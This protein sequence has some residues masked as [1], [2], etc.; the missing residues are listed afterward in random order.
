MTIRT[1]FLAALAVAAVMAS[2]VFAQEQPPPPS[3]QPPGQTQAPGQAAG[4]RG[5]GGPGRAGRGAAPARGGGRSPDGFPQFIRPLASQDVL[6]RG[7]SLYQGNCESCHAA[8]LRG[9]LNK[10]PNLLRSAVAMDDEHGELIGPNVSK[11]NP[12]LNLVADD[13]VAISEYIHSI[14]ATMGAQGSPP[15]RNPVGLQLNVLVGDAQAG[16]A[17]F[18][19]HCASCHSATGDLKGIAAK[20]PDP[21]ALQNA[22]VA[23]AS[24]AG[25]FGGASET[26]RAVT[27]QMPNGQKIDGKLVREDDFDVVLTV[28]DGARRYIPI[29]KGVTV[30]VADPQAAHKKMVLELDD[31]ENKNMHDVT[32]YLATLK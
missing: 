24:G 22:W 17:Y 19:G 6:L 25:G 2:L 9:V 3:D 32:A 11:H 16:K 20:Y 28:T 14:L 21:R 15:G 31:P 30:N 18:D 23:G 12:P 10:G 1:R 29:T 27:V 8:D 4:G 26:G 13:T 5:R 7:Q